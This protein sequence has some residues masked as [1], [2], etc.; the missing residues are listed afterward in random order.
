MSNK[1]PQ[2]ALIFRWLGAGG[3]EF[4]YQG[5]IL[6]VDPFLTRPTLRELIFHPL[7]PNKALLK[8]TLPQADF[9]LITHPHYDHLMDVPE[10]MRYT[11]A[12]AFGSSYA[13]QI[14]QAG[15]IHP[16]RCHV[17]QPGTTLQ[18]GSYSIQVLN[19]GHIN[20]PFFTQKTSLPHISN[21]RHAWDY[22]MDA[23]FSYGLSTPPY[24]ILIWHNLRAANAPRANILFLNSEIAPTE[25]KVLLTNIQP[26]YI[27]PIH[28]DN[29]FRPLDRPL[30]PLIQ[31]THRLFPPIMRF[32]PNNFIRTIQ[33]ILPAAQIIIPKPFE[34]VSFPPA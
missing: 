10:I 19:G 23:C 1:P 26:Q 31:P 24:N 9:I 15:G 34:F 25:L 33:N 12:Q 7:Q 32:N 20:V 3:I 30:Q 18:A 27:V 14:I 8:T 21:P 17:V 4:H 5:V 28:W 2:S 13:V 11:T 29:F 16:Q 6:L 22:Q